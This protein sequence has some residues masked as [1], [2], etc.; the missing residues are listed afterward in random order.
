MTHLFNVD[1]GMAG[2]EAD[3]P[4]EA[5]DICVQILRDHLQAAPMFVVVD[6]EDGTEYEID[7]TERG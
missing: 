6:D 2:V 3:T 5:V 4:Q 1:W 7:Y